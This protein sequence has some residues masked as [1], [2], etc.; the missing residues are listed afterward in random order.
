M[1]R[2]SNAARTLAICHNFTSSVNRGSDGILMLATPLSF[3]KPIILN[4][5]Q[6]NIGLKCLLLP[7]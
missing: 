6:G 5:S 7:R 3:A 4:H 2:G 1:T